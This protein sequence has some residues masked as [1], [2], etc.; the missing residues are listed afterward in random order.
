MVVLGSAWDAGFLDIGER[1]TGVQRGGDEGVP[2]R[3]CGPMAVKS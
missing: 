2:Q 1:Y 3:V